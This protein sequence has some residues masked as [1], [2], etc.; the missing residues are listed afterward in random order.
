MYSKLLF[1]SHDYESKDISSKV[2]FLVFKLFATVNE[3]RELNTLLSV[4]LM[5]LGYLQAI[6]VMKFNYSETVNEVDEFGTFKFLSVLLN[7]MNYLQKMDINTIVQITY[8]IY[9]FTLIII[10]CL[11]YCVY[12]IWRTNIYAYFPFTILMYIFILLDWVLFLPIVVF[13][14]LVPQSYS[15]GLYVLNVILC[16][17]YICLGNII[18]LKI[19]FYIYFI[20][21]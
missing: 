13:L 20:Y 16:L 3:F 14:S 18:F 10:V 9:V 1:I 7:Y 19:F 11:I 8:I 4:I 6:S 21:F 17:F 2:K 5:L 15:F 12:S